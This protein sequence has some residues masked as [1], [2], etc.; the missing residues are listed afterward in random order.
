MV[1]IVYK[2]TTNTELVNSEPLLPGEIQGYVF[3]SL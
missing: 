1:V 3:G 2:I